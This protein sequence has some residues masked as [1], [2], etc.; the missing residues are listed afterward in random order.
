MNKEE[1]E[2]NMIAFI[3]ETEKQLQ[4]A[5]KANDIKK[6]KDDNVVTNIIN[7][8]ERQVKDDN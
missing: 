4:V 5:K 1:V 2:K 6:A 3:E 8:L 7:E